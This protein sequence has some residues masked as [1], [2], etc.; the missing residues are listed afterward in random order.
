MSANY[1]ARAAAL[2]GLDTIPAMSAT[3][4]V[5][6]QDVNGTPIPTDRRTARAF[7]AITP[8]LSEPFMMLGLEL[9]LE[10]LAVVLLVA[11]PPQSP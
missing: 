5:E 9:G 1:G 8:V 3:R 7:G 11:D 4:I 10:V 6:W 2:W